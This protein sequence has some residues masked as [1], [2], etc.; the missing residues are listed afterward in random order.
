VRSS[1]WGSCYC[2]CFRSIH[3]FNRSDEG[4]RLKNAHCRFAQVLGQEYTSRNRLPLTRHAPAPE[5]PVRTAK[6]WKYHVDLCT[7]SLL[8]T[9]PSCGPSLN[10]L[11]PQVFNSVVRALSNGSASHLRVFDLVAPHPALPKMSGSDGTELSREEKMIVISRLHQILRPF[12]L[13]RVKS[14]GALTTTS[15]DRARDWLVREGSYL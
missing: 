7:F 15:K 6:A 1:A 9:G 13:R 11:L 5:Q 2:H 3:V 12:L 4:H 14:Q 10:F 8:F